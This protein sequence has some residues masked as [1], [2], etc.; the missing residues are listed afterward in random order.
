MAKNVIMDKSFR[1]ALNLIDYCDDL[2]A[3][4][5][6]AISNQLLRAG[7]SIGAN[8]HEA[9]NAESKLDFI[10][11]LKVAAKDAEETDYWLELCNQAESYP[12]TKEL[13]PQ[14]HEVKKLLCSIISKTKKNIDNSTN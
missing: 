8:I 2:D 10:H 12:D 5:K 4:K 7:T 1:F 9:Q 3:K 13:L 11:K 6:F 14:L